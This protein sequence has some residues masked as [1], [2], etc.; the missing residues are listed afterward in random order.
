[1]PISTWARNIFFLTSFLAA[2]GVYATDLYQYA[3]DIAEDQIGDK[4]VLGANGPDI[5]DC[6]GLTRYAYRHAGIQL[7]RVTS[8]KACINRGH[9]TE[10]NCV[11]GTNIELVS[12]GNPVTN[13]LAI[14]DLILFDVMQPASGYA[15]HVGIYAGSNKFIH[16]NGKPWGVMTSDLDSDD[17][18][19]YKYFPES[20]RDRIMSIRRIAPDNMRIPS[21]KFSLGGLVK[22]TDD[23]IGACIRKEDFIENCPSKITNNENIGTINSL[24]LWYVLIKDN[25]MEEKNWFWVVDFDSGAYGWVAEKFLEPVGGGGGGS[26]RI[27]D[28]PFADAELK[29]CALDNA[30]SSGWTTVNEVTALYC[31][32]GDF[33]MRGEIKSLDGLQHFSSLE[34]LYVPWNKIDSISPLQ[35]LNSLKGIDAT[36]NYIS[37][38]QE[39]AGLTSLVSLSVTGNNISDIS[40]LRRL[41]KLATFNGAVNNISDISTLASLTKLTWLSLYD[42]SIA[43]IQ[44]LES[45]SEL[46]YL[47]LNRN[48]VTSIIPLAGLHKL[49]MIYLFGNSITNI[50]PLETTTTLTH[51]MLSNNN[52]FD[53]NAL[54]G[55]KNL[56]YLD[57]RGNNGIACKDLDALR[58]ALPLAYFEMPS[59]CVATKIGRCGDPSSGA[60]CSSSLSSSSW[61]LCDAGTVANFR[62]SSGQWLWTCAGSG[63]GTSSSCTE[64]KCATSTTVNGVCGTIVG[65]PWCSTGLTAS[66]QGLCSK[67]TVSIFSAYTTFYGWKC[68][69]QNGGSDTTCLENRCN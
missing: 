8:C 25:G 60:A 54:L 68:L 16:A 35:H 61:G 62:L 31:P 20:W 57:L 42:N 13:D 19:K 56:S 1:M 34:D 51:L 53:V 52:I 24:P 21:S 63:G 32:G 59:S 43:N 27:E 33:Q 29:R 3:V 28:V 17:E 22:V 65:D 14:G 46:Y 18:K 6:S 30:A 5:F 47:D 4:Y 66:S 40:P 44:P 37:T 38:I 7:P 9:C 49:Q 67:G 58:N 15:N 12:Y 39:L 26:M 41:T 10:N 50:E 36:Y 2:F 23:A 45:L 69:G 48:N 55:L 64:Q 11:S